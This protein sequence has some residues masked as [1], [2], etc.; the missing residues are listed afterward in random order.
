MVNFRPPVE[1]NLICNQEINRF[2]LQCQDFTDPNM[3]VIKDKRHLKLEELAVCF[4]L[5]LNTIAPCSASP[6]FDIGET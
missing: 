5:H 2:S 6:K 4:T 3:M 1:I